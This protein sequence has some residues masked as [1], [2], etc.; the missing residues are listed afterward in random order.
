MKLSVDQG[1][2]GH[3][4]RATEENMKNPRTIQLNWKPGVSGIYLLINVKCD[5]LIIDF[6]T[7]C[8]L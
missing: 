6:V 4:L 7:P 8:G 1:A 5:S 3:L 2:L